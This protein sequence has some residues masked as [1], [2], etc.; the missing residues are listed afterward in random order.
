MLRVESMPIERIYRSYLYVK[1]RVIPKRDNIDFICR[2][3]A[4]SMSIER[5]YRS[6]LYVKNT[7]DFHREII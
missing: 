2:L 6:Y 7:E 1:N 5:K 3:R 4:K